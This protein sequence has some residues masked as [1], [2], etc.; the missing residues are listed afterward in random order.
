MWRRVLGDGWNIVVAEIAYR[1]VGFGSHHWEVVDADGRRWFVTADDLD[2]ERSAIV[3]PGDEA[4]TR[5]RAALATAQDLR[6]SGADFVVARF[7]HFAA[8]R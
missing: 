6:V 7:R 2:G 8:S 3:G 4:F 1:P 5:L